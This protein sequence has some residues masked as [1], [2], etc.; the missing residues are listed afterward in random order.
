L[1]AFASEARIL[2]AS[3]TQNHTKISCK[4]AVS[5]QNNIAYI[6]TKQNFFSEKKNR[7]EDKE[8]G[9][10]HGDSIDELISLSIT[11]HC[12][13]PD[14]DRPYKQVYNIYIYIYIVYYIMY[15]YI[16]YIHVIYSIYIL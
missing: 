5:S 4:P 8:E 13:K 7:G 14:A 1:H 12:S 3:D 15:I 6:F 10:E 11:L 2:R 16:Y 9:K